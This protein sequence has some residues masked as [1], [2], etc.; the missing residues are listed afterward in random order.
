MRKKRNSR[1]IQRSNRQNTKNKTRNTVSEEQKTCDQ[2][3]KAIENKSKNRVIK[4]S[5]I[6]HFQILHILIENL[7]SPGTIS[8]GVYG[9]QQLAKICSKVN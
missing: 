8:F 3:K 4:Q 5:S 2:K 7:Q 6:T 1:Q 9:K